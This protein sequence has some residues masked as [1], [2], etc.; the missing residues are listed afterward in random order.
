MKDTTNVTEGIRQQVLDS[1]VILTC[2]H[3]LVFSA[4]NG[5]LVEAA[6]TLYCT[7]LIELYK[8]T[9]LMLNIVPQYY[10]IITRL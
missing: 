8:V 9:V 3:L 5:N 1:I 2:C 6:T 10:P 7:Y 4:N